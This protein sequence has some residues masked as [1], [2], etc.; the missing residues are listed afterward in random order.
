M[1]TDIV[2]SEYVGV[3]S[4]PEV[5]VGTQATTGWRRDEVNQGGLSDFYAQL[6][7][8]AR[9]IIS[10]NMMAEKGAVVGLSAAPKLTADLNRDLIERYGNAWF[11]AVPK[12]IG[13]TGQGKFSVAELTLTAVTSTGYTV[14]ANGAIP[15]NVLVYASGFT[16]SANNGLKVLAGTSTGT[17][18]KTAGL[19]AEASPPTAAVLYVVGIQGATADIVIN[20][21]LNIG[22]TLL[23]FTTLGLTAGAWGWLGGGT[24]ASPGALG[25][26]TAA[27]RGFFQIESIAASEIVVRRT[28]QAWAADT[29]TGKTIQIFFG[30]WW[31]N[32][33]GTHA[34]YR[35]PSYT[36]EMSAP[37]AGSGD[38]VAYAYG[39]GSCVGQVEISAPSEDKV[40]TAMSFVGTNVTAYTTVRAT[41]ASAALEPLGSAA[42]T[43]AD[44]VRRLRVAKNVDETGVQSDILDWKLT[45][46]K[47]VKPQVQQGTLGA[48]RMVFGDFSAMLDLTA[49]FVDTN[50][51]DA[52]RANT[53]CAFDVALRSTDCTVLFDMPSFDPMGG[54]PDIKENEAVT[55]AVQ[56]E[57]WRDRTFSFVCGMTMLPYVPET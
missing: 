53:T 15:N 44:Q 45:I 13:G 8:V 3:Q 39:L 36:L 30:P 56:G 29:G 17:E 5:T 57:S 28:T 25:F 46:G 1:A 52:I 2:Q 19:V 37:G 18:I 50:I 55:L 42:F 32:V 6:K 12:H 35:E 38:T 14:T 26:A 22:S 47:S 49:I 51:C 11:C 4:A 10:P 23:D 20:A 7:R 43:T 54:A 16:N 21:S 48:R 9:N 41:G 24:A 40:V 33:P 27:D 34:D 31:R